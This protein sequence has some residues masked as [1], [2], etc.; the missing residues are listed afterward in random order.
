[1]DP[2]RNFAGRRQ[3]APHTS[4][5][6]RRAAANTIDQSRR[7]HQQVRTSPDPQ[8][9]VDE[10]NATIGRLTRG[11]NAIQTFRDVALKTL[12]E[13][14]EAHE[15]H[16]GHWRMLLTAAIRERDARPNIAQQQDNFARD[17]DAVLPIQPAGQP[18]QNH[19]QP[20]ARVGQQEAAQ[21]QER[22]NRQLQQAQE[23]LDRN[24]LITTKPPDRHSSASHPLYTHF[25]T[26]THTTQ[27][28]VVHV[29][30]HIQS[31]P[32]KSPTLGFFIFTKEGA[33]LNKQEK[34]FQQFFNNFNN[35]F[36]CLKTQK[37]V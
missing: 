17:F 31:R 5:I 4:E 37:I 29:K 3:G 32:Q 1:M 23:G 26:N 2:N 18:N 10:A 19:Q 12:R 30:Q 24:V 22:E 34:N 27:S 33:I 6:A 7:Q 8:Y 9:K 36:R 20:Q 21:R 11:R 35:F 13:L 14:N 25:V 15:A 16:I 28:H